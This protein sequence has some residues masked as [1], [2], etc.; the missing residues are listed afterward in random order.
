MASRMLAII[1]KM[2]IVMFELSYFESVA[3]RCIPLELVLVLI[4][5]DESYIKYH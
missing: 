5:S 2:A 1:N 4:F 3:F